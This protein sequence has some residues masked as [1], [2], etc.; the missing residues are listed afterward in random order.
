MIHRRVFLKIAAVSALIMAS[1]LSVRAVLAQA[2]DQ[3]TDFIKRLAERLVAVVNGPGSVSAKR[4]AMREVIDRNVDVEAVGRF[5]LGRFWNTAT[6]EERQEYLRLFH[7]VLV[8]SINSHLGEYA[9]VRITLGRTVPGDEQSTVAS[10]VE[11]PN[12]PPAEVKWVVRVSSGEPKLID[13]VAE[14]TSMRLTQREDY[15]SYLV[16][17]GSNVQKLIAAMKQQL[18]QNS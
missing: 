6:P 11:R 8:N 2:D 15:A 7:D 1:P 5:C 4:A 3:A 16:H 9:G 10:V 17:N 13:V 12:N 14:G 18:A